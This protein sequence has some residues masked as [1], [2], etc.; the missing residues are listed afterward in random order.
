MNDS[1]SS[2][3]PSDSPSPTVSDL[4]GLQALRFV[5]QHLVFTRPMTD[6]ELKA[7]SPMQILR[8]MLCCAEQARDATDTT[9]R[10]WW[11]HQEAHAHVIYWQH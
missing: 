6:S 7:M 5:G 1:F 3:E 9:V 2:L 4:E 11:I 10:D 8:Y